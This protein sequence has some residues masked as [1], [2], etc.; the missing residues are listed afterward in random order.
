MIAIA[1]PQYDY[2][3]V[4]I[5][6]NDLE[7]R[8]GKG[9]TLTNLLFTLENETAFEHCKK[10]WLVN[11]I[12]DPKAEQSIIALL[13]Q[14]GQTY[15]RIPFET[16]DY[17]LGWT[18]YQKVRYIIKLNHARNRAMEEGR[19]LARWIFPFDS[20][21]FVTDAGWK[22][23]TFYLENLSNK[24]CKIAMYRVRESND[25]VHHFDTKDYDRQESQV[26]IRNENF[27]TFDE[28]IAYAN[29]NKEEFLHRFPKAPYLEYVIRLNDHTRGYIN[30]QRNDI[31]MRSIP[32]LIDLVDRQLIAEQSTPKQP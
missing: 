24:V 5:L 17:D 11:R 31:R 22:N 7:P 30:E 16:D 8:H 29:G 6:G 25:E 12:V 28:S 14:F 21:I 26:A 2:A 13:E 20:N 23:L 18:S 32:I 4:R 10:L 15:I 19:K 1:P 9:Q 3:L 27:D